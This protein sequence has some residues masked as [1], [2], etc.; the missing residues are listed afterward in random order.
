MGEWK[1]L[2]LKNAGVRLIDCVHK[3]PA[4]QRAGFPYVGIPQMKSGRVEFET[5]RLISS[6]DLKEWTKKAKYQTH[7]II[8]SRRTNPGVTA[9]DETG[10]PF[11]LG[12]NLVLL[13]ADGGKVFPPFLRW[14][15]Q[16][17]E[18]WEQIE[19]FLNVGAIFSSLRCG[20]VP[21]FE[22]SIPP[23]P[24]QRAIAS[25][26]SALD[27]KIELNRR[28]NATLERQARALFADWFVDFGPTR[29]K[30]TGQP[31]YLPPETWSL[32]PDRLDDAGV[33]EGWEVSTLGE[34]TLNFDRKRIPLSKKERSVRQGQFPYH[35]ATG[36]MDNVD[37]FLFDG[38]FVLVGEDG[39]VVKDKTGLAFTQYAW[40]RFWVNNHAHVLQG[41]GSVSTEQILMYFQHEPVTPYITGAVQLKLSQGRMNSMPF[42]FPGRALCEAFGETIAPLFERIRL[43]TVESRTLAQTR[44]L[45]LPR[46]MSGEVRV[47][48]AEGIVEGAG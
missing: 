7:D 41:K 38:I 16:G 46:L 18:W 31:P 37:D 6:N 27:D 33:P 35:G 29:A 39:S 30:A 22:L 23:L 47:R 12:Q 40:G 3:T 20:D 45:L 48:A 25:V 4:A 2:A 11:A 14:L 21:N 9:I 28:M 13:R 32:F 1:R 44:D 10:T 19:K 15:T 42:V 36:V 24:E 34:H 8:L 43:N 17:P 26:L 5:A